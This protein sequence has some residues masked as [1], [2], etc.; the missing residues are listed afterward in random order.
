MLTIPATLPAEINDRIMAVMDQVISHYM[1]QLEL[2]F[3]SEVDAERLARAGLQTS[4]HDGMR[5]TDTAALEHVKDAA[6]SLRA[7]IGYS[8]VVDSLVNLIT[9]ETLTEWEE[10]PEFRA[11]ERDFADFMGRHL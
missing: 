1:I 6:G 9:V 2:T 11:L 5:I 4:F 3:E 8:P 10:Q 7:Q